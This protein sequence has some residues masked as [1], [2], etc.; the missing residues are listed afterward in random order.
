MNVSEP[1]LDVRGLTV[2]LRGQDGLALEPVNFELH[3][4][5][6]LSLLGLDTGSQTLLID[7]ILGLHRL[8]EGEVRAFGL[9]VRDPRALDRIGTVRRRSSFPSGLTVREVIQLVSAHY[10]RPAPV[11]QLLTRFSMTGYESLPTG[12]LSPED[13]RWLA[14]LLA[15]SG[16]PELIL[17]DH[18]TVGMDLGWRMQ[19]WDQV[20]DF[21]AA[22]G[23]AL[24]STH[25]TQEVEQFAD[26]VIVF[27]RGKIIAEGTPGEITSNSQMK[28]VSF[29][30]ERV[31]EHCSNGL[32]FD[33]KGEDWFIDTDDPDR[34][35]GLLQREGIAWNSLRVDPGDLHSALLHLDSEERREN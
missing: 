32:H 20:Q 12:D 15:F 11:D 28:R 7:A 31:P 14:F 8:A 19:L 18:P 23:S 27:H 9:P 10:Q 5:E 17:L 4:G 16:D 2:P 34:I 25:L 33:R 21:V 24:S 26:R 30:A 22:G 29:R 1:I 3:R 6:I 35:V 13:Q